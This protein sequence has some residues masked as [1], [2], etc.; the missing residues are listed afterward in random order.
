MAQQRP[1]GLPCPACNPSPAPLHVHHPLH[2]CPPPHCAHQRVDHGHAG[3]HQRRLSE[4][5][6]QH[7]HGVEAVQVGLAVALQLDAGGQLCQDNQVHDDGGG[8]QGVLCVGGWVG[9][10]GVGWGGGRRERGEQKRAWAGARVGRLFIN[11]RR[12]GPPALQHH[13]PS[14]GTPPHSVTD[15]QGASRGGKRACRHPPRRC[16][17]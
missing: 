15:M 2:P 12:T 9:W 14:P 16:C 11:A 10:G 13:P 5:G 7:G 3:G 6:Q 8:Q 1:G 17:A 4:V